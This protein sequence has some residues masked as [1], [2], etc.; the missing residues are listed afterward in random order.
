[1]K[2]ATQTEIYETFLY[3]TITDVRVMQPAALDHYVVMEP[4]GLEHLRVIF[5]EMDN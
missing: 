2:T 4:D 1:M 5:E 3:S